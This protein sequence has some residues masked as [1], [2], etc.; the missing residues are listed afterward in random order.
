MGADRNYLCV[1]PAADADPDALE[2]RLAAGDAFDAWHDRYDDTVVVAGLDADPDPAVETLH[3]V[4]AD[5]ERAFLLHVNDTAMRGEGRVYER[6]G[7]DLVEREAVSGAE[8][9]GVDVVDYVT[10]EYGIHG[11]R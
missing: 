9:Y 7:D 8:R 5:V 6:A 11:P 4:A 2:R 1:E 10:R 3:D